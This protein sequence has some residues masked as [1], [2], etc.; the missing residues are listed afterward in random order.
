V[1]QKILVLGLAFVAFAGCRTPGYRPTEEKIA[2][3]ADTRAALQQASD[4]CDS[5][6]DALDAVIKSAGKDSRKPYDKYVTEVRKLDAAVADVQKRVSDLHTLGDTYFKLWRKEAEKIR[7]K[8]LRKRTEERSFGAQ[9]WFDGVADA[10]QSVD[11]PFSKFERDL[12]DIS[13]YL[14]FNLNQ[15]G[16][17][18]IKD[19]VARAKKDREDGRSLAAYVTLAID[20][21]TSTFDP[22]GRSR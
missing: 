17:R 1:S 2:S 20:R 4:L 15:S 16:I 13:L 9:Q 8:D 12:Q 18:A 6:L 5:A 14:A 22:S 11:G 10:L 19:L 3:L 7:S 21:L